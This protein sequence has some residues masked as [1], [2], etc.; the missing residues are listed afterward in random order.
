MDK[1]EIRC[2]VI[3]VKQGAGHSKRRNNMDEAEHMALHYAT[4]KV[5]EM[6]R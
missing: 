5:S 2:V 4:R 3:K 1:M 6:E